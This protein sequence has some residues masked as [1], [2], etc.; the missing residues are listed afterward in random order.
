MFWVQ[1]SV[2]RREM[3]TG[4]LVGNNERKG[5]RHRCENEIKNTSPR[6]RKSDT[7]DKKQSQENTNSGHL[8]IIIIIIIII[9]HGTPVREANMSTSTIH[10]NYAE[11][12]FMTCRKI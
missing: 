1:T 7:H 11:E 3:A 10:F 5:P 4:S 6:N 8:V 2:G 9:I 12:Y